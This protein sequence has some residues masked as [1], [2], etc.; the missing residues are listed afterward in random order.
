[1]Y[2]QKNF[3]QISEKIELD[4]W[5]WPQKKLISIVPT[6]IRDSDYKL[7]NKYFCEK[8]VALNWGAASQAFLY[9][10]QFDT[11]FLPLINML[12]IFIS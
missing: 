9:L 11:I 12:V 6:K 2:G 5:K 8:N 1:M 7:V 4:K 3:W 10:G